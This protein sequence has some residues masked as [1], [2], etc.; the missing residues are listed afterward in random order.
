ML[1]RILVT[2]KTSKHTIL[3][4]TQLAL[5]LRNNTLNNILYTCSLPFT[6]IITSHLDPS[7]QTCQSSFPTIPLLS[8]PTKL[9]HTLVVITSSTRY[10]HPTVFFLTHHFLLL[11]FYVVL[12]R[13]SHSGFSLYTKNRNYGPS[14]Y[15]SKKCDPL[16]SLK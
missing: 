5:I 12:I 3:M 15:V 14:I 4:H 10:S 7:F 1:L 11:K 16:R 2:L 13:T 8:S 9:L 6:T